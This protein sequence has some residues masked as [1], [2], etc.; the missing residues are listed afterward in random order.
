MKIEK[1]F[2]NGTYFLIAAR[3]L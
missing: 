3:R 1:E 2:F